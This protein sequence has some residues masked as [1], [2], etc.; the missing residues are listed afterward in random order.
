MESPW[1]I[2]VKRREGTTK[3]VVR[4][5]PLRGDAVRAHFTVKLSRGGLRIGGGGGWRDRERENASDGT[6]G[7]RTTRELE[8][9]KW[10]KREKRK[11][12]EENRWG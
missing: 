10:G 2:E 11:E 1:W 6:R 9:E 4:V 8:A 3:V 5:P 7:R 12:W